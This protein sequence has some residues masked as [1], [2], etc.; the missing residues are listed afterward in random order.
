MLRT[1]RFPC[2]LPK[3]EADVL[4]AESGRIYTD[5]LTRHYRLYRK[6]GVWLTPYNGKRVQDMTGGPTTL[7]AHSRDA[8]Q[9]AFYKACKTAKA[10][11]QAGLETKYPYHHKRWRTSIWKAPK[12]MARKPGVLLLKRARSLPAVSVSLPSHLAAL[13]AAVF[14]EMRLVWDRA[15]RHYTWHLVVEDGGVPEAAPG[16]ATA[17]V[18]LGE[19]HPAALTDGTETVIIT[20]RAL[21]ANQQYTAKRLSEIRARQARKQQGSRAFRRLQRRKRRFLAKQKRRT[22]DMEHKISRAV[23]NWAKERQI[24]T[25]PLGMCA[26]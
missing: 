9:E 23:V 1:V 18:D 25:L 13:P 22:R 14:L 26:T 15:A 5:T 20:C 7:H 24:G 6:Q 10:C 16:T 8:A 4:N 19:I 12:G 21:R 11:K 17:A 3:A 2:A